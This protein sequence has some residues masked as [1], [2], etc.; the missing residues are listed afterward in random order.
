M[1]DIALPIISLGIEDTDASDESDGETNS[2]TE[3]RPPYPIVA[4]S[5]TIDPFS[6]SGQD[7]RWPPEIQAEYDQFLHDE[8]NYVSEGV[9]DRF[10]P[11]SRLFVG[12]IL[13]IYLSVT[14][15]GN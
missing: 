10:P 14:R 3:D 12:M 1:E 6:V 5:P 4:T 15:Y 2:D 9:W 11:G 13:I 7:I 8:R